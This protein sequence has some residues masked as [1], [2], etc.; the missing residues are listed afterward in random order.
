[1]QPL[2]RAAQLAALQQP[3]PLDILILGGG[4]NGAGTLRDLA[5]RNYTHSA[6]L[7]LALVEKNHFSSGTSGKNSQLIHGGLRYLKNL[8]FGLVREAL[9]ERTTLLKIA[10]DL[11][12][13]QPFLLPLYSLWNRLQYSTGLAIYD[14]LAGQV[15]WPLPHRR[16]SR[17]EALELVP[18]LR[19]ENL[20]GASVFYD[21]RVHS[22]RLVL[23]NLWEAARH[24]ATI[25]NYVEARSWRKDGDLW[26]VTL[27]DTLA[28]HTWSVTT[29]DIIDARGSW[30]DTDKLRLVRGSHIVVP[31]LIPGDTAISYF[32]PAGRIVFFLPWFGSTLVGTTDVDHEA[33]ADD[34]HISAE[35]VAYL[36]R[37]IREVFPNAPQNTEPL[38]V[39]SSLRPLV[40]NTATS[41]T[42]T[43]REHKIA[44]DER[45]ILRITGGKYTTYR[46]MSEQ[47]SDLSLALIAPQLQPVHLTAETVIAGNEPEPLRAMLDP[48]PET[49]SEQLRYAIT[50]E[51]AQ[52]LSDFLFVNTTRGYQQ[53]WDAATL[54]PLAQQMARLLKWDD[55]GIE[56]E[57]Q[58]VLNDLQQPAR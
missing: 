52:H 11:V 39:F 55:A 56:A 40:K 2:N 37:I 35:E 57:V 26:H 10:P 9:H 51:M 44:R 16:L 43:S 32:E 54:T 6:N 31:R 7:R 29:R 34:V 22:A 53:S 36:Q 21:C 5:L 47:A 27:A 38:A 49:L 28:N 3:E 15:N 45:G 12:W 8:E 58:A 1:M 20:K 50:H 4:I 42:K 41:A 23:E 17:D 18:D 48:S 19:A 14:A 25:A 30:S 24:G 13:P 33:S 46:V